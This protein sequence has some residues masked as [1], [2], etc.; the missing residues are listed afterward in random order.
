MILS[1][2]TT[3]ALLLMH[4]SAQAA[5]AG[6]IATGVMEKIASVVIGF[7]SRNRKRRTSLAVLWE[8]GT[9]IDEAVFGL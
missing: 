8:N 1:I 5:V 6:F 7:E 2:R 9:S 3:V 4:T